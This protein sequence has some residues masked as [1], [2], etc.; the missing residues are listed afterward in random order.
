MF[1]FIFA[2]HTDLM[3]SYMGTTVN[4]PQYLF[5]WNYSSERYIYKF[6]ISL[7]KSMLEIPSVH[8]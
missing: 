7:N 3:L 2:E 6:I 8:R 1:V 4:K 5:S